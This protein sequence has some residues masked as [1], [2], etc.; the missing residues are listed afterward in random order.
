M[1]QRCRVKVTYQE[2]RGIG[3]KGEKS[4]T[5]E[6]LVY[7]KAF[8]DHIHRVNQ[9]LSNDGVED[10]STHQDDGTLESTPIRRVVAA[11]TAMISRCLCASSLSHVFMVWESRGADQGRMADTGDRLMD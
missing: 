10:G 2:F 1:L 3:H 5:K 4:N 8:E 7:L 6:F 11:M 9:N